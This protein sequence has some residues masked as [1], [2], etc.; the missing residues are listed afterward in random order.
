MIRAPRQLPPLDA[1]LSDLGQPTPAMIGRALGVHERTVYHWLARGHAPR[2]AHLALFWES[3]WGR[4]QI[5][6]DSENAAMW[7]RGEAEA[8]RR[9][10]A[11]LRARVARLERVGHFGSANAPYLV[12]VAAAGVEGVQQIAAEP[13]RHVRPPSGPQLVAL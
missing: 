1:I 2:P 4:S 7:A 12:A 11:A 6:A 5:S 8:L 13:L 10:V 3:T 9:E